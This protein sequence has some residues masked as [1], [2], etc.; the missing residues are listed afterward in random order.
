L[1][2]KLC[3]RLVVC[4]QTAQTSDVKRINLRKL[5]EPEVRKQY[6]IKIENRFA[7]LENLNDKEDINR[8][9]ENIKDNIKI[10]AKGSLGL[11]E[12]KQRKQ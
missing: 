12:W 8:A 10:S 1:A 9:W 7:T 4:K 5:S 6:H 2:A 11:N 3:E